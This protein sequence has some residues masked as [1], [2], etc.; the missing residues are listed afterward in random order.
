LK[1]LL[2]QIHNLPLE[3]AI[4]QMNFSPKGQS[5]RVLEVLKF[6]QEQV[7]SDKKNIENMYIG[8]DLL[9]FIE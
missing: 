6:L 5:E 3:V 1:F 8:I 2:A 4:T 7:K 9:A